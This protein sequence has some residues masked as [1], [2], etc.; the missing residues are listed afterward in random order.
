MSLLRGSAAN[1]SET[2]SRPPADAPIATMGE[3]NVHYLYEPDECQRGIGF[4][5]RLSMGVT[6]TVGWQAVP[7]LVFTLSKSEAALKQGEFLCAGRHSDTRR[8]LL[9]PATPTG[10]ENSRQLTGVRT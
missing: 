8:L 6:R 2:A 10:E 5:N 9:S 3:A 7:G 4:R 1:S